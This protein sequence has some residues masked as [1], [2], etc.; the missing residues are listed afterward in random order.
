MTN[1]E[2]TLDEYLD[3]VDRWKE[4]ASKKRDRQPNHCSLS[5]TAPEAERVLI[6]VYRKMSF[7]DKWRQIAELYRT[8]RLLHEAGFRQRRPDA[9]DDDLLDDWMEL[10]IEPDLLRSIRESRYGPV[11]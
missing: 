1:M 8:A 7:D 5:D 3:E 11:R 2:R 4:A 10:T 9:P 6:D